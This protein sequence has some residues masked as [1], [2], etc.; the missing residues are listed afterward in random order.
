MK[1]NLY[2]YFVE[3]IA[4][5]KKNRALEMLFDVIKSRRHREWTKTHEAL[6]ETFLGLCIDLRKSQTAK[7]GLH[8][9]KTAVQ[10]VSEFLQIF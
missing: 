1:I 3:L 7:D 5:G 4:V 10:A 2:Y 6:M 9:Y 8:Q